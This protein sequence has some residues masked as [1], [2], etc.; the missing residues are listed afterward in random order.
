MTSNW[1][2]CSLIY[3]DTKYGITNRWDKNNLTLV[4][5]ILERRENFNIR[6]GIRL[7]SNLTVEQAFE[8]GFDHI[9]LCI[10]TGKPRYDNLPGYFAKGVRSAADFLMNLQQLFALV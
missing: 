7:G 5:L 2:Q 6:G 10:G 8:R 9:A 4:R 1:N 3:N